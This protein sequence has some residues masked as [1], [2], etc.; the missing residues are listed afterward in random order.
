V[1]LIAAWDRYLADK[2]QWSHH[3]FV[4]DMPQA[5]KSL[6]IL[7]LPLDLQLGLLLAYHSQDVL[8][9]HLIL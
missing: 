2:V 1:F 5:G 3:D 6:S 7:V 4:E 9:L 8:A